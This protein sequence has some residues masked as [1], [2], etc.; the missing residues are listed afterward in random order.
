MAELRCS[1]SMCSSIYS[2][3]IFAELFRGAKCCLKNPCLD[4]LPGV[5]SKVVLVQYN[6]ARPTLY[7]YVS[8]S[9]SQV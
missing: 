2:T 7:I 9:R 6:K 4:M 8:L 1:S 5:V 3:G